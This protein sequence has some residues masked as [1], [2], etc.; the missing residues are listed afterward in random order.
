MLQGN[1]F[2]HLFQ[3]NNCILQAAGSD[4]WGNITTGIEL[5]KKKLGKDAYGFT[6]PLILDKMGNKFGKSEGNALWL[7]IN[8]TSSY[9]LY[10]YLINTD[11]DMVIHYL[12]VFTFYQ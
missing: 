4:Q 8:K 6:M 1:D 2:V 11:D 10:Q 7:D 12:K 5:I 3:N 9:E